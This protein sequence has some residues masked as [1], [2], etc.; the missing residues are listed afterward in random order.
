M[1]RSLR[2]DHPRRFHIIIAFNGLSENCA[3]YLERGRT[4][5]VIGRV[6]TRE[7]EDREGTKHHV[8]QVIAEKVTFL[9]ASRREESSAAPRPGKPAPQSESEPDSVPF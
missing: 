2:A 8:M 1:N 7:Y 4:C 9:G 5:A 3:A 6:Q